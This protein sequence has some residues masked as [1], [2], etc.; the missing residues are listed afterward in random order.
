MMSTFIHPTALVSPTARIGANVNIGPFC[1]IEDKVI[2]KSGCSI[3]SFVHISNNTHIGKDCQIFQ[4]SVIGEIPQDL[5]YGGEE[6]KLIVG[7]RTKIREFCTINKGTK[8]NGETVIGNDVLLMAYVHIAHDCIIGDN[9]I[10]ANGVQL[11]G[12]VEIGD[13]VTV[14]GMTPVH[15]F[16]KIGC[17][18]FIGGG[19][20]IV[21][22]IPPYILA[23]GEPLKYAGIN[24]IGL[25]RRNF[26]SDVRDLIKKI[27]KI[28]F[29]SKTNISD[30]M[31]LINNDYSEFKEA[32]IIM[33]FIKNSSRGLI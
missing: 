5:K 7:D 4:G 19:Y 3:N 26:P 33:E 32:N 15:Q 27:Y 25:R 6:T 2:I 31:N 18:S 30:S 22:D 24:S 20:R 21:Q 11:G 9:V 10:L 12:H 1:V 23:M 8:A 17:H 13:W 14:G 29:K 16:T 28:I